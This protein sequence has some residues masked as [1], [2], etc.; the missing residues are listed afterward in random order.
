MKRLFFPMVLGSMIMLSSCGI[1]LAFTLN[2]N[3]NTTQ[4]Q[5]QSNNYSIIGKARGSDTATYIFGIGG[6][7]KKQLYANAYARMMDNA[8]LNNG[9]KAVVNIVT[10]EY[11]G[12]VH[13]I[14]TR[15]ITTV[16][17]NVVE[18]TK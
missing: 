6:L 5:L 15:R 17:C 16:S 7:K 12:G 14:F 8:K 9:S 13:P 1:D 2:Q 3:T 10:E 11:I 18:F 4:V